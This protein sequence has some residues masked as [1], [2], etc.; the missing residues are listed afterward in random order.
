MD[1]FNN[2]KNEKLQLILETHTNKSNK[3]LGNILLTLEHDFQSLKS[4]IVE[5]TE[6]LTEVENTYDAVYNEL[7]K[8]LNRKK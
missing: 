4:A 7:E 1:K 5:L 8:R 3:D 2:M 6:T